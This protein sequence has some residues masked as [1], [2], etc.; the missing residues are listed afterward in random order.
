[1]P[2]FGRGTTQKNIPQRGL[3]TLKQSTTSKKSISS[4]TNQSNNTN[5]FQKN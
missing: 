5:A 2:A 4:Q 1:M 3:T